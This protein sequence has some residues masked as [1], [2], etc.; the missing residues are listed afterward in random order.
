MGKKQKKYR[1]RVFDSIEKVRNLVLRAHKFERK[2]KKKIK[3]LLHEIETQIVEVEGRYILF[4]KNELKQKLQTLFPK[5]RVFRKDPS[6]IEFSDTLRLLVGGEEAF[7]E[8]LKHIEKA[9]KN[10]FIQMFIWKNDNIGNKIAKKLLQ[11]ADRGV[12]VTIHKDAL[13]SI[14]EIGGPSKRGLL[15][16]K[17][18]FLWTIIS[19]TILLFYSEP[20]PKNP[21]DF[22]IAD[23]LLKHPNVQIIKDLFLR[24]HSKYFIFD[25]EILITG[26]MNIGDEYYKD[27][28]GKNARHDFMMEMKSKIVVKKFRDRLRGSRHDNFDYGTSVEFSLNLYHKRGK[29]FEIAPK[30][31]ELLGMAKKEVI[32]EMAYLGA[33]RVTR[34]LIKIVNTG[35]VVK[36]ILPEKANVQDALN[37]RIAKIL[38]EKTNNKIEIF[39][40][41]KPL[42]SKALLIDHKY[43]F[44]GS[45]NLNAGGLRSLKETNVIVNDSHCQFTKD[46]Y[47]ALMADIKISKRVH[48]IEDIRYNR[49]I[50]FLENMIGKFY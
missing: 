6:V 46:L 34:K 24:N 48:K 20:Q 41:P 5:H 2:E 10:I 37:K 45:A 9:K 42:H 26:G 33:P 29:Q 16:S 27:F 36:L 30:F 31:E 28:P 22:S 32:I 1:K 3:H 18:S 23:K 43:T 12:S 40:Y 50:A 44:L 15:K 35:I 47:R 25:D 19:K 8:I 13:G 49:V 39:L 14:F 11:A 4:F 21:P 38:M 17:L 7:G